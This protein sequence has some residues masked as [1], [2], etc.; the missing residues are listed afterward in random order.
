MNSHQRYLEGVLLLVGIGGE[1]A[2][3]ARRDVRGQVARDGRY[4]HRPGMGFDGGNLSV[5][6]AVPR[7]VIA[8]AIDHGTA[9]GSRTAATAAHHPAI[10]VFHLQNDL[11]RIRCGL[12]EV[13]LKKLTSPGFEKLV[14]ASCAR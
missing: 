9:R 2:G 6:A 11:M 13:K 10:A 7:R 12:G 1:F 3:V 4:G 5:V 8:V 14:T